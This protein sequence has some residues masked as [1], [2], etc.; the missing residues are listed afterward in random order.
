MQIRGQAQ[1]V[2]SIVFLASAIAL[3]PQ[4]MNLNF[5]VE[6][7]KKMDI[8]ERRAK[9]ID[10]VLRP[11]PWREPLMHHFKTALGNFE[12]KDS[13]IVFRY[14]EAP[15]RDLWLVQI[16][17]A[18]T[19]SEALPAGRGIVGWQSYPAKLFMLNL[20]E[21]SNASASKIYKIDWS[22]NSEPIRFFACAFGRYVLVENLPNGLSRFYFIDADAKAGL[23][24]SGYT[25]LALGKDRAPAEITSVE[26]SSC[27]DFYLAG[28]FG[29]ARVAY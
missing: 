6:A 26:S 15:G 5:S 8:P 12:L 22:T 27:Q 14:K 23:K 3:P 24:I 4:T 9:A 29:V 21:R 19:M 16:G 11:Q 10:L 20:G 7:R 25:T 18:P 28:S 13:Q 1:R 17:F 2:K